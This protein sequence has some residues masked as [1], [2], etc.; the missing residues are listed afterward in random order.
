MRS[1]NRLAV[2]VVNCSRKIAVA[3]RGSEERISRMVPCISFLTSPGVPTARSFPRC[4]DRKSTRLN[5]SHLGI[6][7][8][9]FCLKKKKK[10]QKGPL[11]GISELSASANLGGGGGV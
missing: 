10:Q 9:V 2:A 4:I 7:Y 11:T 3:L 8:A 6:S 1:P 5:S